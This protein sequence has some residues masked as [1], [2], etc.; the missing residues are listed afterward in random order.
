MQTFKLTEDELT[1]LEF[2]GSSSFLMSVGE[3]LLFVPFPA[4]FTG[5]IVMVFCRLINVSARL[6]YALSSNTYIVLWAFLYG[7]ST[8]HYEK[9]K[10]NEL[11]QVRELRLMEWIRYGLIILGGSVVF[12]FLTEWV[13]DIINILFEYL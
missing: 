6:V 8:N 5:S 10:L 12:S 13:I 11:V 1:S 7:I 9:K 4:T 3:Q 2:Y